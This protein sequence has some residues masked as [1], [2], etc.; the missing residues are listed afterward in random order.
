MLVARFE[1]DY[2]NIN[3]YRFIK[4]ILELYSVWF[5]ECIRMTY[6]IYRILSITKCN[7][8]K[9]HFALLHFMFS[10]FSQSHRNCFVLYTNI[11]MIEYCNDCHSS[12]NTRRPN[13]S[14]P[15]QR[16]REETLWLAEL[17]V[18]CVKKQIQ[19]LHTNVQ[20]GPGREGQFQ[21][22]FLFVVFFFFFDFDQLNCV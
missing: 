15:R 14:R 22:I 12:W 11:I 10:Y 18:E 1:G 4:M 9:T 6:R 8:F 16:Y 20:E 17:A 3:R 2:F 21:T 7:I 13:P 5:C 19:R